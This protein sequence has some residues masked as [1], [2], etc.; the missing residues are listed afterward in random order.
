MCTASGEEHGLVNV[1]PNSV[2]FTDFKHMSPEN[3]EK[4]RK[5][6]KEDAKM[7]KARYINRRSNNERFEQPYCKW[8]GEPIRMYKLIPEQIYELPKGFVK[9]VN[10]MKMPLREGLQSVDGKDVQ[11]N[12]APLSRDSFETLHELVPVSF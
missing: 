9:Q 8:P 11:G 4:C 2:P 7:V 10:A 12:G 1:L 5:E 6:L 3:A